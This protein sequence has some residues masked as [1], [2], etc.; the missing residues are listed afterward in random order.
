[1]LYKHF[2]DL[3]TFH[4]TVKKKK[5]KK[6]PIKVNSRDF[7]ETSAQWLDYITKQQQKNTIEFTLHTSC[8]SIKTYYMLL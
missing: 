5:K 2:I 3:R 1:M 4:S 8:Y 6:C 7:N